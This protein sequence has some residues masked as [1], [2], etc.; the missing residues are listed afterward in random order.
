MLKPGDE[1]P[2]FTARDQH[3][4][5]RSLGELTRDSCLVLYFY[6][7]DFT[8]VCTREACA[9]RDHFVELAEAGAT[10]AG[11]SYDGVETH[12][13]FADVHELPFPLLDDSD[14]A[15]TTAYG[16]V[17]LL[18]LMPK[19]VTY[20]IGTDRRILGAF[21]HELSAQRHVDDV[22]KLLANR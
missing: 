3:G 22:K 6:P 5:E 21:R 20:V 18:K 8:F 14:R 10:V 1:A 17:G 7:K 19:R 13:R 16:A 9:F 2:D 12:K 4:E 15:L 11:V